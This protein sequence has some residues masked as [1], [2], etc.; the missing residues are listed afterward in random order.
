VPS[1]FRSSLLV[2]FRSSPFARLSESM[3]TDCQT[4]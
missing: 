3:A 1:A 4:S 2:A